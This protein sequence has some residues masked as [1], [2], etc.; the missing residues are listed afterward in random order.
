MNW[1]KGIVGGM[2]VFMLF[3][4]A[5]SVYMFMA[6]EDQYDHQYYEKGL[7]FD[8]FYNKE[9]QVVKDHAQPVIKISGGIITLTFDQSAKGTITFMRPSNDAMDKTYN[10]DGKEAQF[11]V[12]LVGK[13]Q[14]QF[15]FDWV[16][17]NKAYLYQKEVYLK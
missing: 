3:I 4:I 14:W 13:G 7:N 11:P 16:S 15:V 5:M 9:A 6:P 1:G 17:N 8:K 10:I 2:I 12:V